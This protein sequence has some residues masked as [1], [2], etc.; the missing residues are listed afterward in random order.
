MKRKRKYKKPE[1]IKIELEFKELIRST[2]GGGCPSLYRWDGKEFVEENNI[3]PQSERLSFFKR[4]IRDFYLL[5][6]KPSVRQKSLHF[7]IKESELEVSYFKKFELWTIEYPRGYNLGVSNL[8]EPVLF[9]QPVLPL[10]AIDNQGEDRLFELSSFNWIAPNTYYS[11][12]P[13]DVLDLTFENLNGSS[14]KLIIVDPISLDDLMKKAYAGCCPNI[15]AQLKESIHVILEGV[16]E[17]T[18]V[19]SRKNFYPEIIDLTPFKEKLKN[20]SVIKIRLAFTSFHKVCF[21]GLDATPQIP[22][23]VNR[24][25]LQKAYHTGIGEVTSLLTQEDESYV[26]LI[27]GEELDLYF[28]VPK[29]S[30]KNANQEIGYMLLT[31]G[32]YL[33]ITKIIRVNNYLASS[34]YLSA[35]V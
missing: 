5:Q 9:K 17:I 15:G 16:G 33:P 22:L 12:T 14:L 20:K 27:P 29:F 19:C 2:T 35:Q 31:T 21:V 4:T 7:K 32:Y 23:K 34:S 11:S 6:K 10:E 26:K 28:P 25:N 30:N 1:L 3:L 8:G 13:G 18:V 24:Y